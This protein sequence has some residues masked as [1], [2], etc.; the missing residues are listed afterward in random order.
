MGLRARASIAPVSRR[1]PQCGSEFDDSVAFCGNDG[2]ITVQAGE[3]DR[4]LGQ[5]FGE[6]VVV[7]RV[8]DGA[9]GR[10]YEGRHAQ[11]RQKVA[12]KVLHDDVARD[13][14]AVE[15]FRREFETARDIDSP[16]IV[17]VIDFGDTGDGSF[18]MTM[19]FLEGEELG[20]ALRRGGALPIA[21]T[22]RALCQI[23]LGLD[24]AHSFGVIHRDLKPDNLFLCAD[25]GETVR[26][27]DF[28]SVKLQMETGPKLTAFGTTLGSP[29]YMSPEQAMGRADVDN[30]TDV[31]A[32]AAIL[33]ECLA[34]KVAFEGGT[35]AEILMKIVNEMPPPISGLRPGLPHS[36]DDVLERAL[37]KEK[38]Q[39]HAG[40]VELMADVLG[41][42]GLPC[43]PD[44]AGVQGWGQKPVAE[45][46]AAL[47]SAT[48]RPAQ[49][50]GAPAAPAPM[51]RPV[52]P[53]APAPAAPAVLSAPPPAGGMSPMM[54][55]AIVAVA[56]L[57]LLAL[58][59]GI[60][61]ALFL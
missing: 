36:L 61:V 46:E 37:A 59:G 16:Y 60:L 14:V 1:C 10:V 58:A 44:R 17:R 52:T 39:R 42:F 15:R 9:M 3:Q 29:F 41:A 28:G 4:R 34:G 22:L 43:T 50:F 8:A 5:R 57:G 19:E 38:R 54:I 25:S 21:R 26:I 55:L 47:A 18:F 40:T 56:G 48:P 49:A 12:V 35:V 45:I 33:F 53:M 6:F 31:F 7:A 20:T 30:R 11:T 51:A 13:R 2:A 24:D 27:L 32:L 23:A